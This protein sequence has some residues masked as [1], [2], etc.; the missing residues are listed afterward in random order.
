MRRDLDDA[1]HHG[2]NWLWR[3]RMSEGV[4]W[5][6]PVLAGDR[7]YITNQSGTTI[8]FRATPEKYEQLA[9]N[10]LDEPSN[11]TIAISHGEIFCGRP[12]ICSASPRNERIEQSAVS[13]YLAPFGPATAQHGNEGGQT[14]GTRSWGR[15]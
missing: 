1:Q 15:E 12:S 2:F 4:I 7:L 9:E 8:V 3:S 11:S 5:S 6:S 10:K 14:V 13:E